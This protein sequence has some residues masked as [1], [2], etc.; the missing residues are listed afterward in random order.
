VTNLLAVVALLFV[1]MGGASA[2]GKG[3]VSPVTMAAL[4][5]ATQCGMSMPQGEM[6]LAC[7]M[8]HPDRW[9]AGLV[10]GHGDGVW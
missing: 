8:I 9:V 7:H 6:L 5:A 10:A 2:R 1:T 4:E 3:V